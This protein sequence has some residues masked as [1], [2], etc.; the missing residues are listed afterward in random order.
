[1]ASKFTHMVV[2]GIQFFMGCWTEGLSSSMAIDQ[3]QPS[4]SYGPLHRAAYNM[5]TGFIKAS[6]E[7][8]SWRESTNKMVVTVFYNLITGVTLHHFCHIVFIRN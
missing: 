8:K 6:K 4:C 7:E 2:G 3:R 1:M 5:T